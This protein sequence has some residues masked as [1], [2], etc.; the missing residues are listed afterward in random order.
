MNILV[1]GANGL[2]GSAI[3]RSI[4]P[5][6]GDYYYFAD[7][8]NVTSVTCKYKKNYEEDALCLDYEGGN[9]TDPDDV[10]RIFN[11]FEPDVVIHTAARVGGIGGNMAGH[12]EFFHDNLLM[13]VHVIEQ[14]RIH[15]VQKL[16]A[17][18]SVCVFPNDLSIL[19]EDKMHDG[20][21]VE[22][23][24]AYAHAK[25]MVD[26]Q[27]EAYRAQYG[28]KNYCAIIPGNLFGPNDNFS[29]TAGHVIPMLIHKLY[30]A[31][32]QQKPFTIWGDGN[33]LREFIYVDDLA[34]AILTLIEMD[35]LPHRLI[36]SGERQYTI[37][38]VVNEL[39]RASNSNV[40]PIWDTTK[41]NGQRSRQSDKTLLY[42][43]LPGFKFSSVEEGLKKSWTWFEENY[44][45]VRQ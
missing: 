37:K 13:N 17:F 6:M 41:P 38:E 43:T 16:I 44:P 14:A 2:V 3:R 30:L 33:S 26:I 39:I 29:L 5:R 7:R 36:I 35:N 12:G 1:T 19:H 28:V 10:K 40:T 4:H 15:K 45:N 24:F 31:K 32:H 21:P 9:L 23:N 34:R 20:K 18:P 22:S 42:K 25:R 27:M 11:R 8:E